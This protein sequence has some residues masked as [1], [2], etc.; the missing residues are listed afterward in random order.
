MNLNKSK[1]NKL[2]TSTNHILVTL[3]N[4]VIYNNLKKCHFCRFNGKLGRFK[5]LFVETSN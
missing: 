1:I 3:N 4:L 2:T 5:I